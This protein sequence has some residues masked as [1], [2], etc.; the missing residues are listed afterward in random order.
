MRVIH[1]SGNADSLEPSSMNGS[2]LLELMLHYIEIVGT[3]WGW[4]VYS[5]EFSER[6]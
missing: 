2:R 4:G 5:A 1:K 6:V 3:G